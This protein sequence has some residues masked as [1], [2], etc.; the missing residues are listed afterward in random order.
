MRNGE[1][2]F[3]W[4]STGGSPPLRASLAESLECDVAIVGGGYT[5]LWTAW[6]LKQARPDWRVVVLERRWCGF[7][8]SGRN[9]GWLSGLLAGSRER[10]ADEFGRDAVIAAQREMFRAVEEVRDFCTE[11][12]VDCDLVLS[13]SLDVARSAPSLA[14]L[15]ERVEWQRSWGFG[16]DDWRLLGRDEVLERVGVANARGGVFTPHCARVHPVK[17]VRGLAEA[18]ERA[19]VEIYEDTDVRRLTAPLGTARRHDVTARWT[20]R[21]TEG[22]SHALAPRSLIP[23]NSSMV[24]TAPLGDERWAEIGWERFETLRDA[25]H[26][27]CYLQRTADGRIAIGGRGRPYRYGSRTDVNGELGD[28]TVAELQRRLT[29]MFPS[30]ADTEIEHA[31][32]GV[33]G[34]SRDWC[35]AV[36]VDR[37]TGQATAGG[38]V[39]DGVS[40]ANLAGR[41]LRDLILDEDTPLTR[42]PWAHHRPRRW[43]PEPLRYAGVHAVYGLYRAADAVEERTQEPSRLAS[44]ANRIAGR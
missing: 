10:W 15:R 9:G 32:G 29:Q 4:A 28:A 20:V 34:V 18:V 12:G 39:G 36:S 24:V 33:L 30:V 2:S 13:G 1:T 25:A 22:Y 5:G 42:A 41:T 3:W 6:Y 26:T 43:E 37:G 35:P 14:R 40:T 19:G 17:L 11:E 44:I 38:Y 8:A 31:W 16:D 7:G 23:M 21:A 27:F